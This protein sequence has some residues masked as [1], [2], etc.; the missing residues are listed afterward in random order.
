MK[1]QKKNVTILDSIA[2]L[3]ILLTSNID[4]FNSES[5]I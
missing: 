2:Q 4:Y 3:S 1:I 5:K